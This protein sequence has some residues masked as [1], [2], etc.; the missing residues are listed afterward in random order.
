MKHWIFSILIAL[1]FFAFAQP[2]GDAPYKKVKGWPPLVLKTVDEKDFTS[3]DLK[4][5]NT[6]IMFFSPSCHH[7]KDQMDDMLKRQKDLSSYQVILATYQP[8]QEMKDFHKYYQ[9][10]RHSNYVL[11]RDTKFLLPPF[12]K[13][14]NL[15]YLALYDKKGNFITSYE[16]N[17]KVDA[18]LKAFKSK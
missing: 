7:C 18:M 8:E 3:K 10:N 6:I 2:E 9:L 13:I 17:V 14:G 4:N 16:G 5:Q 1:P 15:P 11:G 12:Y